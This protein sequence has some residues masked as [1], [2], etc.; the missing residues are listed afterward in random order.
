MDQLS[1][2]DD[3]HG[4]NKSIVC[5]YTHTYKFGTRLTFDDKIFKTKSATKLL[6]TSITNDLKWNPNTN[7]IVKKAYAGMQRLQKI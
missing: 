3:Q 7:H 6:S 1:K 4:K 2:N 5:S